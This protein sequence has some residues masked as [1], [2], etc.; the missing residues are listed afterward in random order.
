MSIYAYMYNA[1][2]LWDKLENAEVAL[3]LRQSR[4]KKE[5]CKVCIYIYVYIRICVLCLH[6]NG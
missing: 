4:V 5:D 2:G 3:I 1:D 6:A